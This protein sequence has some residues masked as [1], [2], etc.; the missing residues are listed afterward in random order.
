MKKI[1]KRRNLIALELH[2]NGLFKPKTEK[3]PTKYNRKTKHKKTFLDATS[4]N[5]GKISLE[6]L[7]EE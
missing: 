1:L 7:G 2:T 5:K 4:E 6:T 3:D